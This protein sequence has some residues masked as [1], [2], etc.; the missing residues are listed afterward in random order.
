V[1][2]IRALMLV[3]N[4]A[5]AAILAAVVQAD[6]IVLMSGA[7]ISPPALDEIQAHFDRGFRVGIGV[8]IGIFLCLAAVQAW[9]LTQLGR[10]GRLA[11]A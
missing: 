10:P 2:L 4:L 3:R 1:R 6:H 5:A 9:R 8:S 7:G 11:A